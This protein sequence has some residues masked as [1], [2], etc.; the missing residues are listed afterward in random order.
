MTSC[1]S[2]LSYTILYGGRHVI[3]VNPL[4]LI[5]PASEIVFYGCVQCAEAIRFINIRLWICLPL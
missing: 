3:D 4:R 5:T 2:Y 1:T